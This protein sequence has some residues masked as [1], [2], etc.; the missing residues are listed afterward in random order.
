M[1]RIILLLLLTNS[2]SFCFSQNNAAKITYRVSLEKD[3]LEK[4]NANSKAS[5]S[6]KA[7][8]QLMNEAEDVNAFLLFNNQVAQYEVEKKLENEVNK[9][10]NLSWFFAGGNALYYTDL[11]RN[12]N[13][14]QTD[15]TGST[16]RITHKPREWILTKESKQI[17]DFL[18]Y[19]AIIKGNPLFTA[20]YTPQIPINHGPRGYNGLPGLI[21]EL[22]LNKYYWIVTKIE[23]NH[24]DSKNIIEPTKGKLITEEEYRNFSKGFFKDK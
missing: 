3:K 24:K 11:S 16:S 22:H 5:E 1:Y 14:T 10:I 21:L 8:I 15:A 20:W 9:K 17:E 18:C 6:K 4:I 23:F 2:F 12:F 13:I 7:A 19:K